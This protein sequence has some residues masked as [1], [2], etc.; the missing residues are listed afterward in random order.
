MSNYS[1][2]ETPSPRQPN[3]RFHHPPHHL[4][5]RGGQAY[6]PPLPGFHHGSS[7]HGNVNS[8]TSVAPSSSTAATSIVS[9]TN[10]HH[11][12]GY[13]G[14]HFQ[15]V[16]HPASAQSSPYFGPPPPPL[17]PPDTWSVSPKN[18]VGRHDSTSSTIYQSSPYF[19]DAPALRG[20]GSAGSSESSTTSTTATVCRPVPAKSAFMCFTDAKRE[21]IREKMGPHTKVRLSVMISPDRLLELRL[22]KSFH[23]CTFIIKGWARRGSRSRMAKVTS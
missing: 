6:P 23:R 22:T 10:I 20:S 16:M 11:Y 3:Y 4:A 7:P 17:L 15:H 18:A 1:D 12:S 5:I 14:D 8:S 19:S 13:T 21:E 9:S 2:D